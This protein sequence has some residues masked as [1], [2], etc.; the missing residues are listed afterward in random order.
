MKAF[1]NFQKTL[2]TSLC[3]TTNVTSQLLHSIS[4]NRFVCKVIISFKMIQNERNLF[5]DFVAYL[6]SMNPSTLEVSFFEILLNSFRYKIF[7]YYNLDE[8]KILCDCFNS[9]KQVNI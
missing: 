1:I 8:K 2:E 3:L 7:N 5:H 6:R 4:K 9:S